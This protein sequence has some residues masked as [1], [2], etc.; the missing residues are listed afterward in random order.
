MHSY[1]RVCFY[2]MLYSN[3]NTISHKLVWESFRHVLEFAVLNILLAQL[4][5]RT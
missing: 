1:F 5:T 2:G 3:F 4:T